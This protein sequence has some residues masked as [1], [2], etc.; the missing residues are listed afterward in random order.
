MKIQNK[1][2]WIII[3]LLFGCIVSVQSADNIKELRKQQTALLTEIKKENKSLKENQKSIRNLQ[4]KM[5]LLG[6]QIETKEQ[7]GKTIKNGISILEKQIQG[8]KIQIDQLEKTLQLKK[9]CYAV[10]I[11]RI[12]QQKNNQDQL[13]FILSASNI[14][15]SFHRIL[16]LKE[17]SKW[18]KEQGEEIIAQQNA[19]IA[20]KQDLEHNVKEKTNLAKVVKKEEEK[21]QMQEK[22]KEIE[23][24]NLTRNTKKIQ[25]EVDRKKIQAEALNREIAR[26]VREEIA[27]AKKAAAKANV[28]KKTETTDNYAMTK[29]EQFLSADF[30]KNKG[31][32]PF[33]LK[34]N[35]CIVCRFGQQQYSNMGNIHYNSNGIDIK[36]TQGNS[37]RAVFDGV[38]TRVFILPGYQTS[39]IIRH[40]NYLTLYSHVEQ[41]F[42][43]QGEKIKTGQIIGKIYTDRE[44]E[45][46]TILHFELWREQTKLNPEAWLCQ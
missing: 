8:K 9:E 7:L 12:Y 43:K 45:N 31:K 11:Q 21:L 25:E 20:G 6:K 27:A 4:Q 22:T 44:N 34:G 32:L 46:S 33:P 35:Y 40:G 37:V 5:D 13:F 1:I 10:A 15:Q 41:I 16:Y 26:I 2:Q 30:T 39:V 23:K 3:L 24:E 29:E 42:V 36:T 18:R 17:Y 14:A 19:V 28:E 38:V